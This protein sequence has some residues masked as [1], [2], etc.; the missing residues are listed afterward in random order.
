MDF[1]EL[2]SK[3]RRAVLRVLRLDDGPPE[4]FKLGLYRARVDKAASDGS[5][6][7]VTPEDTRISP[8]QRV[9][10]RV[11]IPGAVAVV[12]P[13]AIVLYG[14]EAGDPARAYCTPLWEAGAGVVKLVLNGDVVHLGAESGSQFVALANLVQERFEQLLNAINTAGVVANDGGAAL[15]ANIVAALNLLGWPASMAA[16]QVKAK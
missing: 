1:E 9:P 11:G 5:T 15:K 16:A 7:D 4:L 8:D 13:G 10:L 12:E 14:W 6:L 2:T 3:F